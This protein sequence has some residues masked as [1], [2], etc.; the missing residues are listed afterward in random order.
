AAR[1]IAETKKAILKRLDAPLSFQPYKSKKHRNDTYYRIF[2]GNFT[3][4]YVVNDNVMEVR[5]F[6]YSKRNIENII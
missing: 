2:V 6:I 1:L 3:V 4:F 5:R